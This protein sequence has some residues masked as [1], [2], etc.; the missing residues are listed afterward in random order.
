MPGAVFLEGEKVNLRT[1]EEEDIEFLRDGINNP[2]IREFLT[3]R[4]PVN[5]EQEKE[6]FQDIISNQKDIHL[7]I[8]IEEKIIGIVSL[9]EVEDE[10]RVAKIGIWIETNHHGKVMEQK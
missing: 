10:I 9:E 6:F 1:I 8:C 4:K 5:L 2:E 7:A 3:A